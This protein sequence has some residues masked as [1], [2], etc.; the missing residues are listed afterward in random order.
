MKLVIF[1]Q[2]YGANLGDQLIAQCL[3]AELRSMCP[4]WDVVVEDLAAR[5]GPVIHGGARIKR[6]IALKIL[7][8]LPPVA[9]RLIAERMLNRLARRK[10]IPRWRRA[11]ADAN[12]V[13]IGGGGIFADNDLNFPIKIA[14]AINVATERAL[15]VAIHAVG[16]GSLWSTTAKHIVAK[17]LARARLCSIT[18]RDD[19]ARNAWNRELA[20]FAGPVIGTAADPALTAG[21]HFEFAPRLSNAP[22]S[23]GIC[24]TSPTAL[25]YH[26]SGVAVPRRMDRWYIDI[27]R[28]LV[29]R[30]HRVFGFTTGAIEDVRFAAELSPRF[31]LATGDQGVVLAPFASAQ[32]LVEAVAGFSAIVAHRL[33]ALIVGFAWGVPGLALAWDAKML[34]QMEMMGYPNR[35]A[36]PAKLTPSAAAE[37]VARLLREGVSE[38]H[39]DRLAKAG[40]RAT[41][42][43]VAA[44]R[45]A[46][47]DD[48]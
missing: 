21:S 24:L 22:P 39:R 4:D 13:V 17:S 1:T 47:P 38:R 5:D 43:L 10:L 28:E 37:Q 27:A 42:E 14:T 33:H 30:G 23:I 36:D 12:A 15:P 8:S 32:E 18:V 29:G 3:A 35:L 6:M 11:L 34:G 41:E 20:S 16:V 9:R 25:R 7:Q 44:L 31:R 45:T 19:G 2:L 40:H 46:V 48:G 26:S